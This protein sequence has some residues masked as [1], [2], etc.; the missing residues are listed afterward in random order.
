[1]FLPQSERQSLAPIQHNWQNY[2]PSK[3]IRNPNLEGKIVIAVPAET[4]ET[5]KQRFSGPQTRSAHLGT[6][7]VRPQKIHCKKVKLFSI[8]IILEVPKLLML[9][10]HKNCYWSILRRF[11]R[12]CILTR[13]R[14]RERERERERAG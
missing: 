1:V 12:G 9:T 11:N 6:R 5:R 3:V 13:D 10:H 8:L 7:F 14:G 2:S 4:E